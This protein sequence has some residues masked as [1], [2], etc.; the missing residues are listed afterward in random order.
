MIYFLDGN[1]EVIKIVRSSA[2]ISDIQTQELPEDNSLLKDYL[3]V[4]L[5]NDERL[6]DAQYMAIKSYDGNRNS[7]DMYRIVNELVPDNATEFEGV[8]VAPY[9]LEGVVVEDI[10]P[11]GWTIERTTNQILKDSDW[12]L[13]YVDDNLPTVTTNFYY[14]SAKDSLKKLQELTGV[15]FTFKVEIS[16]N[17]ITDKWVEVYRELGNRTLKRFNYGTNALTVKRETSH[18]ELYTALIGRGKGEEVG[19][20]EAGDATYGRKINFADIEWKKSAGKPVDKPK[21]QKYIELPQATAEFGVKMLDGRKVPRIGLVEFSDTEE[22]E[23]LIQQTW[24]SLQEYARPKVL[25]SA[26]VAN[27]GDT[28]IGDTVT[29]HRHD[30]NMHYKTRVRKVM[31]NRK[32]NNKTQVEIG[33]VVHTPST[34]RQGQINSAL[35][36]V[37]DDLENVRGEITEARSSADGK[38]TNFYG[39]VEPERKKVGDTWFRDHPSL[40]GESQILV[41]NGEAWELVMDTSET[42]KITEDV[43]EAKG[44]AETARDNAL[45]IATD[46]MEGTS[47]YKHTQDIGLASKNSDGTIN[48]II[49]LGSDGTAYIG[50]ENIV[51]DGDTIVDGTF[52]ITD[53]MIAPNAEIDGAKIQDATIGNAKIANLDVGKISGN[54]TNF[55]QSNWNSAA[56]GDVRITGSGMRSTASDGSQVYIQNGVVGARNPNGAGLGHIGYKNMGDSPHLAIQAS[57]GAHFSIFTRPS[58]NTDFHAMQITNDWRTEINTSETR[59]KELYAGDTKVNELVSLGS[60]ETSAIGAILNNGNRIAIKGYSGA[61]LGVGGNSQSPTKY[62]RIFMIDSTRGYMYRRLSM[63]GNDITNQSDRRLKLNIKATDISSLDSIKSINFVEFDRTNGNHD[64]IGVIAQDTPSLALYDSERDVWSI[65]SSKQIM[66]NSHAIQQL[67]LAH[68]NTNLVASEAL[69]L[70]EETNILALNNKSEIDLLKEENK[71][72]R[73]EIQKL[74]EA[75]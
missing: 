64:A 47:F 70:A 4:R 55:V 21:G 68:D 33:D 54:A 35:N 36:N 52:T 43:L 73:T 19:E 59:V 65:N 63:E 72:L 53:K 61:E 46:L 51:L 45:N 39:N 44:I 75:A 13:G 37:A 7:F 25:F 22:P 38:N 69:I 17:K 16:G 42:T 2:V 49:N 34:K 67:S 26:T 10:R 57:W 24:Q 50:G 1:Q 30:L 32:N 3:S 14:L 60:I 9:E 41:W 27:I 62:K 12:R 11:Q 29:I 71:E 23:I 18:S 74:K 6:F 28:G 48:S 56:G 40:T 8:Q 66:M 58:Q 20:T 15:E 5:K 31:R